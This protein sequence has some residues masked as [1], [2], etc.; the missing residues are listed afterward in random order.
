MSIFIFI[1]VNYYNFKSINDYLGHIRGDEV[2]KEVAKKINSI[3]YREF[4]IN[5]RFGGDEFCIFEE[6][7]SVLIIKEKIKR[8]SKILEKTYIGKN[9]ERIS[10]SASIGIVSY[11]YDGTNLKE[12]IEKADR[13]LYKSKENGKNQVTIYKD[14]FSISI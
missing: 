14:N 5:A 13:A 4:N 3:F 7:S 1:R 8:L 2:L 11:P 9:N 12:L 10:I 6:N